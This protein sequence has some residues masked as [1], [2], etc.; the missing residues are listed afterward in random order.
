M[1]TVCRK[2]FKLIGTIIMILLCLAPMTLFVTISFGFYS[3]I[4]VFPTNMINNNNLIRNTTDDLSSSSKSKID[5]SFII[6]SRNDNYGENPILRL[7]FTLQN[8]MLYQWLSHNISIEIIIIE[9]NTINSKPH[10]W[11]FPLIQQL[12]K[13]YKDKFKI[14]DD[15]N[16]KK[17]LYF[18]SIP[19]YYNDRL[20]CNQDEY[21]PF[22]EYHAKNIGLRRS[23]GIWKLVMNIDDLWTDN[24]LN[25]VAYSIS[26]NLLDRNG[27]YQARRGSGF[28]I[29]EDRD[30]YIM[31]YVNK[32]DIIPTKRYPNL[33]KKARNYTKMYEE[34]LYPYKR[35]N[36]TVGRNGVVSGPGDFTLFHGDILYKYYVGGFIESCHNVHLDT[37]FV[38]R[39]INING[40]NAY[41]INFKCSYFHIEH[42]KNRLF[43]KNK[44]EI[45][46]NDRNLYKNKSFNC[47]QTGRRIRDLWPDSIV[48]KK[49]LPLNESDSF[50]RTVYLNTYKNW[51]PKDENF[52]IS[53]AF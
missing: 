35:L 27:L 51:G 7:R 20:N 31:D 36:V 3:P 52:S 13:M 41:Y 48:S 43:F 49:E 30:R 50:W 1:S 15:N 16:Y 8:L 37:E 26:Y 32:S 28:D 25:F 19:S 2:H 17:I 9:W 34:C 33:Y 21:C 47:N 23:K 46:E 29:N 45:D 24:L 38:L 40:L 44:T 6:T 18:Y 39:Q 22:Y 12:I 53:K 10:L 4:I 11:E 42:T 14:M 5:L